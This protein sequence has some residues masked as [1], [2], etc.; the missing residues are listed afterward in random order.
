MVRV[1][2][3]GPAVAGIQLEIDGFKVPE[4]VN[5]TIKCPIDG[6]VTI[7]VLTYATTPFEVEFSK[8]V[9][10]VFKDAG[11]RERL[12]SLIERWP[13]GSVC[14]AELKEILK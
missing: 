12:E 9:N 7:E 8:E 3:P 6:L 11:L 4:L 5:L 13:Q 1:S 10:V 14:A 2:Q